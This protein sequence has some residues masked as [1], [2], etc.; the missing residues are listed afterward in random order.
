M[1]NK[2]NF[3]LYRDIPT[4]SDYP[5]RTEI[6]QGKEFLV[7]PVVMMVEGVHNGSAGPI[8]HRASDFCRFPGAWNDT[9]VVIYHPMVDDTPVSA[10][11]P[12]LIDAV[13][14]GRTYNCFCE[15]KKLKG[16]LWFDVI[17]TNE[18]DS[19]L[20][21]AV[22]CC[23]PIDVSIGVYT[24]DR[25]ESGIWGRGEE[26]KAIALNH[27]P[28]HLAVLPGEQGACSWEDGCGIR[29]NKEGKEME[30]KELTI[31]KENNITRLN[32]LQSGYKEL[33]NKVQ[34]QL[35]QLDNGNQVHYLEEIYGDYFIYRKDMPDSIK[36]FRRDY[37]I[38]ENNEVE[39][40][41][42]LTEVKREVSFV[43]MINS[44][45]RIRRDTPM[46][47]KDKPCCKEKVQMLIE[48]DL[49]VYT[50]S[51]REWLEKLEEPVIDRMVSIQ[52]ELM[53][54]KEGKKEDGKEMKKED[55]VQAL[56][57]TMQDDNE[58]LSL[59]PKE[60]RA[61]VEHGMKLHE[62]HRKKLIAYVS[63]NTDVYTE[64]EL[65]E[66]KT[67]F[68]EKLS[69][70]VKPQVNYAGQGAG[71]GDKDFSVNREKEVDYEDIPLPIGVE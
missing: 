29:I 60:M 17:K 47:N 58:Y 26:Y 15:D 36:Y 27:R 28:D 39:F 43:S 1:E 23:S 2:S 55:L 54:N 66:M 37:S 59:L 31:L 51:D 65:K 63:K 19:N 5:T 52:D 61:S 10:R 42:N 33:I 49:G 45:R 69:K 50:E 62:D 9:P 7:V 24:D 25:I 34:S 64:D 6:L 11:S 21:P 38:N 44:K 12:E 56:R 57:E 8:L 71:Y 3:T 16:E 13:V 46:A 14:V 18:V 53:T 22:Q 41:E 67:D 30:E 70:A 35:D 48:S 4:Q 40:G 68:L 20:I 32:I